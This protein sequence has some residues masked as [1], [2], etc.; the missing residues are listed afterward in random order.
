VPEEVV[1][2]LARLKA[3]YD[4]FQFR[5]LARIIHYRPR[6]P[7]RPR[8]AA[9]EINPFPPGGG[10]LGW[11]AVSHWHIAD[12][13]PALSSSPS[14]SPVKGEGMKQRWPTL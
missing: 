10:R 4:G 9:R 6:S 1:E 2:A 7:C 8:W 11:G 5:E 12:D 14:P 13:I 3:L